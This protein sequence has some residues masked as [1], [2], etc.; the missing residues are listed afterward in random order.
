MTN[1]EEMKHNFQQVTE[2]QTDLKHMQWHTVRE[3]ERQ[4]AFWK[5]ENQ[6]QQQQ[7]CFTV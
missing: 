4:F 2:A 1:C 3:A 6:Q 7:L 5:W